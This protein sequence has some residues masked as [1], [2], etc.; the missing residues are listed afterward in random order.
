MDAHPKLPG[1]SSTQVD[2]HPL[3]SWDAHPNATRKKV[4]LSR[5]P[6]LDL[7]DSQ[8]RG[9]KFLSQTARILAL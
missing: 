5:L 1:K 4:N 7:K 3:D 2:S 8:D 6:P 9:E